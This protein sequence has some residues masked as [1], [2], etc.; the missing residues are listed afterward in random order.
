MNSKTTK[1]TTTTSSTM[2]MTDGGKK[3]IKT[4]DH[5]EKGHNTTGK[6]DESEND[7]TNPTFHSTIYD[8]GVGDDRNSGSKICGSGSSD[9]GDNGI[10]ERALASYFDIHSIKEDW[11]RQHKPWLYLDR[12]RYKT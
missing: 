7:A 5:D 4:G 10:E 1:K 11:N 12:L 2:T 3:D 6:D 9:S 8:D